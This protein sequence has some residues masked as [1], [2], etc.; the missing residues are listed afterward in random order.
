MMN[1]DDLLLLA[2]WRRYAASGVALQ[3]RIK[4]TL[5]AREVARQV[6]ISHTAVYSWEHGYPSRKPSGVAGLKYA[7]LMEKLSAQIES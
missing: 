6:G 1:Q 2:K 4:S 3:L 5:S 7:K